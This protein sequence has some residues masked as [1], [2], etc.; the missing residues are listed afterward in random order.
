MKGIISLVARKKK[1]V[2]RKRRTNKEIVDDI[3]QRNVEKYQQEGLSGKPFDL[4][5]YTSGFYHRQ[6]EVKK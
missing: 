2:R 6:F 5:R 3:F 1:A 4:R